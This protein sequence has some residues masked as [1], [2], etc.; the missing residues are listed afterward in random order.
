[1]RERSH[2]LILLDTIEHIRRGGRANALIPVLNRVTKVLDIKPILG[3]VDGYLKLQKLVRSYERGLRQI[4]RE[5][6]ALGPIEHL[7]VMHTRCPEVASI[8]AHALAGELGF[9]ERDIPIAETGP[10]L[11]VHGGPGVIGV[12]AVRRAG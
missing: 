1:V 12:A 9:P 2:L 3:V 7:A 10:A 5:I 4:R 11:A 6:A 8:L